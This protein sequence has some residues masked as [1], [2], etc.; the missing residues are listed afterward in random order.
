MSTLEKEGC[1][2]CWREYS[3]EVLP[4]SSSCGHSFCGDCSQG[5]RNCPLCRK[6]LAPPAQRPTNYPLLSLV[7]RLNSISTVERRDQANQTER[8]KFPRRVVEQ[9][10]VPPSQPQKPIKLK[11]T[12]VSSGSIR[13]FEVVF[14]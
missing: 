8:V 6:R 14:N 13:R 9:D 4:V 11:F 2:V 3:S 10:L 1:P 12:K 5:L 7:N